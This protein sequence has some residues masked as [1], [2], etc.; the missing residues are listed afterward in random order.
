MLKPTVYNLYLVKKKRFI[1]IYLGIADM[2]NCGSL[3]SFGF[4]YIYRY[5]YIY[6]DNN[7]TLPTTI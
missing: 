4:I 1:F 3:K 5:I 6:I 7:N 2:E